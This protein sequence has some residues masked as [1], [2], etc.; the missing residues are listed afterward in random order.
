VRDLV[1]AHL[2]LW[3]ARSRLRREPVGT[4]TMRDIAATAAVSGDAR[5]AESLAEAIG[6]AATYGLFRPLCLVRALALQ[7]LLTR[8]GITGSEIRVGVRRRDGVFA[9]HAWV[10]WGDTLLGDDP[11]HVATFTEVDDIRVLA[12]Q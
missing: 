4:L 11:A 6:T 7:D 8:H 9:A 12:G 10:R 3:R 5:R 2:A 1:A